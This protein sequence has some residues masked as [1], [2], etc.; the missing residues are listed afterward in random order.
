LS[1]SIRETIGVNYPTSYNFPVVGGLAAT[2][3]VSLFLDQIFIG[4]VVFVK[5]KF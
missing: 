4:V 1:N 3:F 5:K 2:T